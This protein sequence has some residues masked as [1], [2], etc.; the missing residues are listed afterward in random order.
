MREKNGEGHG[1]KEQFSMQIL[2]YGTQLYATED[3]GCDFTPG[4]MRAEAFWYDEVDFESAKP[5]IEP[6]KETEAVGKL[7]LKAKM[8]LAPNEKFF[9]EGFVHVKPGL[10]RYI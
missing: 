4:S 1:F 3:L 2:E 8:S 5:A 10:T 6:L 9:Q 7:R